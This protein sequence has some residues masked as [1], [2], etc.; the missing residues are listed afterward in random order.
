ML[1]LARGL[2]AIDTRSLAL[3]RMALATLFLVDVGQR[4]WLFADFYSQD[5][6][7]PARLGQAHAGS[8]LSLYF[9][10]FSDAWQGALLGLTM[11][12]AAMLL[13]GWKTWLVTPALF[14][15]VLSLHVRSPLAL[16][17]GDAAARYLL[18]WLA[19]V[20]AGASWSL[21]ARGKPAGHGWVA[22]PATAGLLVQMAGIYVWAGLSKLRSPW[23]HDGTALAQ[24][25]A[26][27][28]WTGPLG[29]WL[30]AHPHWLPGLTY[31]TVIVE[32]VVPYGLFAPPP[33]R[34]LSL[35][36]L[37]AF[38]F[39]LGASI[40]LGLIPWILSAGLV[41]FLDWGARE[42]APARPA[43]WQ[44][45][46][47]LLLAWPVM[48]C[49]NLHSL[50][51][52][53]P[54]PPALARPLR[55]VLAEQSWQ[56]YLYPYPENFRLQVRQGET[57]FGLGARREGWP[58]LAASPALERLWASYRT[59]M[60]LYDG[61]ADAARQQ[62]WKQ[63]SDWFSGGPLVVAKEVRRPFPPGETPGGVQ[64]LIR[65]DELYRR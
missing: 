18:F 65:V 26:G 8:A 57:V 47:A 12:L 29:A 13:A 20:P 22:G 36:V 11:A 49:T 38:N 34:Y 21:D 15:L 45:A 51:G 60:Y 24:A 54:W 9:L 14:V 17:V 50:L 25:L 44:Q 43:R 41:L 31:A 10:S 40:Q 1:R 39:V 30:Y 27:D 35:A 55:A 61:V 58:P 37:L 64:E 53:G 52:S 46:V 63:F 19:L 7:Y 56:M 33:V 32:A 5:G 48:L 16:D 28:T 4:L 42:P 62:E 2:I 3:F 6:V 59:R 23:W